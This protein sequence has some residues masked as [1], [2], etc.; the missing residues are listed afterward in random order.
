MVWE[1]ASFRPSEI[2]V[3][4]LSQDIKSRPERP[5]NVSTKIVAD[6]VDFAKYK[7]KRKKAKEKLQKY[8]MSEKRKQKMYETILR[9]DK[10]YGRIQRPM[11]FVRKE[12]YNDP[13]EE[14]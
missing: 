12:M 2:A 3:V 6:I 7:S 11:L 9:H 1:A 5:L 10:R 8:L 4:S 14:S 13:T